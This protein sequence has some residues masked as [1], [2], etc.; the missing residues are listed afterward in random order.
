MGKQL[1]SEGGEA[2]TALQQTDSKM[3]VGKKSSKTAK[4]AW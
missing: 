3:A 2:I 4:K 1:G